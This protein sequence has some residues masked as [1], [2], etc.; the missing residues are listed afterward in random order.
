MMTVKDKIQA[1]I[2]RQRATNCYRLVAIDTEYYLHLSGEVETSDVNYAWL[3]TQ[4]QAH[5]LRMKWKRE[6]REWPFAL[7]PRK[8]EFKPLGKAA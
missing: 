5:R 4:G 7:R 8:A 3:G 2:E 6:G 1:G